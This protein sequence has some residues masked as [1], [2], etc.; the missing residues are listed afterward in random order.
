M[1]RRPLPPPKPKR[2]PAEPKET[3]PFRTYACWP[4]G[5]EAEEKRVWAEY[6][7]L[8]VWAVSPEK[9][10]MALKKLIKDGDDWGIEELRGKIA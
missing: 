6:H 2:A 9:A 3:L 4:P 8:I 7:P 1:T 10:R 5:T